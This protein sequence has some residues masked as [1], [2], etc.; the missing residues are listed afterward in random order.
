M[1]HDPLAFVL[2]MI[3]AIETARELSAG[4]G[5]TEFFGDQRAQW[6][7]YSQIIIL[8][9]AA[10][11]LS[12]DFCDQHLRIPWSA[13]IGMRHRLVHGYDSVDWGRVWNTLKNDLPPLLEQLRAL[14]PNKGQH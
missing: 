13:A 8:G 1:R 10:S 2:D 14:L 4:L 9:E 5:E 7:V 3:R 11:R 12:R 6:A